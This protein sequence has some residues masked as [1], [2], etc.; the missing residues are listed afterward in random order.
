MQS[1]DFPPDEAFR[2]RTLTSLSILDTPPEERFDRLTRLAQRLFDVPIALVSLIDSNRQWFKS[3]QGLDVRETPRDVSFC[4]HAILGND[5]LVVPD[6]AADARFAD[7]PLVT[8]EPFIRFYAGCPLK[9]PNGSLLGTLCVIDR[10]AREFSHDDRAALRDLAAIVEQ[11]LAILF[12]A[13]M[14]ELTGVYN[15]RGFMMLAPQVLKLCQRQL[16]PATLAFFDLDGLKPVND[17][18]GHGEGDV[19]LTV[20]ATHLRRSLR[21]S[22]LVARL[23]G[24]EFA[25]LCIDTTRDKVTTVIERLQEGL[26]AYNR[27]AERGYE[28]RFSSGVV[29]VDPEHPL[30]LDALL[31][32][33]DVLMYESKGR[34]AR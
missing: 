23:G 29:Q 2:L 16:T 8:G 33:G 28:I 32:E 10:Q 7:N 5:L 17:R 6:A 12:L 3:C 22:D 21:A 30:S 27:E 19:A 20:F 25:A 11:E 15:R 31:R 13:T 1:P 26:D 9:A 34:R 4:A 14:D 24:D 18:F